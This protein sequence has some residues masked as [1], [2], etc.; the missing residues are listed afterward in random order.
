MWCAFSLLLLP[1][2]QWG[3]C[4]SRVGRGY[5]GRIQGRGGLH[6]E[7]SVGRVAWVDPEGSWGRPKVGMVNALRVNPGLGAG[8]YDPR[9][10]SDCIASIQYPCLLVKPC[11][12][13]PHLCHPTTQVSPHPSPAQP[14]PATTPPSATTH[15]H[16]PGSTTLG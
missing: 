13:P 11:P 5:R 16:H 1:L 6:W 15:P 10:H 4:G 3:E 7:S 14:H 2:P 9:F 8:T 12:A